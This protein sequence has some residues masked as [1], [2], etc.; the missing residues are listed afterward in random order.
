MSTTVNENIVPKLSKTSIPYRLKTGLK[1]TNGEYFQCYD[2]LN[3]KMLP[4]HNPLMSN[5]HVYVEENIFTFPK[6]R[7]I[8]Q[9]VPTHSVYKLPTAFANITKISATDRVILFLRQSAT[10]KMPNIALPNTLNAKELHDRMKDPAIKYYKNKVLIMHH[11]GNINR[12]QGNGLYQFEKVPEQWPYTPY[13]IVINPYNG[14]MYVNNLVLHSQFMQYQCGNYNSSSTGVCIDGHFAYRTSDDSGLERLT[15]ME[16]KAITTS[17]N[18]TKLAGDLIPVLMENGKIKENINMFISFTAALLLL[19]P[20]TLSFH[21]SHKNTACP[22]ILSSLYLTWLDE[23][24]IINRLKNSINDANNAYFPQTGSL[25][26]ED[27][28]A[29]LINTLNKLKIAVH[30]GTETGAKE[31]MSY[32][33]SFSNLHVPNKI[34]NLKNIEEFKA[35]LLQNGIYSNELVNRMIESPQFMIGDSIYEDNGEHNTTVSDRYFENTQNFF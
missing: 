6:P 8:K 22:G 7:F 32:I 27:E 23:W 1:I 3:G 9:K 11:S 13:A 2:N 10:L 35:Y 30:T 28:K 14:D 12:S 19:S 34:K 20:S 25:F 16:G 26:S 15:S 18:T 31:P 4:V 33:S 21:Y 5:E 29:L 17:T 24:D